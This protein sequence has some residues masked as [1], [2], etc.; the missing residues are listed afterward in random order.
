MQS[1]T[2]PFVTCAI[3]LAAACV[4]LLSAL[5]VQLSASTTLA[6]A[7][8]THHA[9]LVGEEKYAG[10]NYLRGAHNDVNRMGSALRK[11]E[12]EPYDVVSLTDVSKSKVLSAIRTFQPGGSRAAKFG[13]VTLFYFSGHGMS[14]EKAG[15]DMNGALCC[16]NSSGSVTSSQC[17]TA[18]E[19][20]SEL[21]KVRGRVV[22]LLDCCYSGQHV[23]EAKSNGIT[24][25]SV[26]EQEDGSMA[27]ADEASAGNV[28]ASQAVADEALANF[29]SAF[30][31]EC[32]A[33]SNGLS[34]MSGESKFY[35]MASSSRSSQSMTFSMS[36]NGK[37]IYFGLFTFQ[38]LGS[39]G[40]GY[41]DNEFDASIPADLDDD[42]E[43]TFA[44][45]F[46]RTESQVEKYAPSMA[47]QAYPKN[48]GLV[49]FNRASV[50]A[51]QEVADTAVSVVALK[52]QDTSTSRPLSTWIKKLTAKKHRFTVTWKSVKTDGVRGY[53]IRYATKKSMSNAKTKTVKGA[54]ST[55]LTAKKLKS[56]KK[57]YVKVRTY[58]VVNGK[59]VY[60]AWSVKKSIRVK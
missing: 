25:Q 11:L 22:I 6:W 53:Q 23:V 51:P 47:S 55:K 3:F 34:L 24:L 37:K 45:A 46:A 42:R 58:K 20:S 35:V 16:M 21:K 17:I 39:I 38:L 19:L 44:E 54:K 50:V 49:V 15:S 14:G 30:E 26:G 9:I 40:Y 13:D 36:R 56:G 4:V 29:M 27:T 2:H 5:F 43:V 59:R 10:D 28:A 12:G 7:G 8:G 31:G 1:K 33:S 32:V 57:Y 60:S 18:S 48:A 52:V 41:Y